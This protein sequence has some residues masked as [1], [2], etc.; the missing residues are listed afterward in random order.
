MVGREEVREE[1]RG[2]SSFYPPGWI[3]KW[4]RDNAGERLMIAANAQ[5]EYVRPRHKAEDNARRSTAE[6]A[7]AV[8]MSSRGWKSKST[9]QRFRRGQH[10]MLTI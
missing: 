4:T 6:I 2:G 10:T 5:I 1:W 7:Q 9:K 3:Q 8:R